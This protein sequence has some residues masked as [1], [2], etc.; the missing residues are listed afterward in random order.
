VAHR[1]RAVGCP[2]DAAA[3]D[4]QAR[5]ML[6]GFLRL[7]NRLDGRSPPPPAVE[8]VSAAAL[9]RAAADCLREWAARPDGPAGAGRTALT[10]T[11]CAELVEQLADVTADLEA[12]VETAVRAARVPWWR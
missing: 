11:Y 6:D 8:R 9:R 7:A 3:I 12:P 1:Y 4:H 10:L 5:L 2:D